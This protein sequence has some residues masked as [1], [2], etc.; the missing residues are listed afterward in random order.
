MT[1][2]RK[3]L[4]F[5]SGPACVGA[6][7]LLFSAVVA[8]AQGTPKGFW[9]VPGAAASHSGW[10]KA[11]ADINPDTVTKNFKLLWKLKL[12]N[13]GKATSFSEPLLTPGLI[14]GKGFKDM[15]DGLIDMRQ[16]LVGESDID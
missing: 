15:L 13:G 7:G 6:A 16:A 12:G 14:T 3:S 8:H 9:P 4:H 11:E 5:P 10:Q 2:Q 1:A